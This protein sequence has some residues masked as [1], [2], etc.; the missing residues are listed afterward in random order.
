MAK[1]TYK[2]NTV[3]KAKKPGRKFRF[4]FGFFKDRRLHLSMGFFLLAASFFLLTAFVSY[5]FTGKADQS[6]VEA[7]GETGLTSSGLDS[8]NWFGLL[9]AI[10]SHYFIYRWFGVASFLIPPFLFVL[11]SYI[12]FKKQI[13]SLGRAFQF[14]LFFLFWTSAVFGYIT[15]EETGSSEFSFL[16]GGIGYELAVM[17]NGFMGW[18]TFLFLILT[19]LVFVVFFFDIT[20]LLGF[21][22]KHRA[23]KKAENAG[24]VGDVGERHEISPPGLEDEKEEIAGNWVLKEEAKPGK[25]TPP[26][27]LELDIIDVKR[28]ESREESVD[29]GRPSNAPKFSFEGKPSPEKS[30]AQLE[31]YDPTLNLKFLSIS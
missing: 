22:S 21:A 9:G 18:G 17:L 11:G 28:G 5:L 26:A 1:N 23:E 27:D 14:V 25:K 12:I 19:L 2:S 16:A 29:S 10:S 4:G 31:N 13:V 30:V 8:R 15:L 24:A 7:I 3:K 6:V 20:Q